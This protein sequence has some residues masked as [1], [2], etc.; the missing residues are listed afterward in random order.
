[1]SFRLTLL[2]FTTIFV[3]AFTSAYSSAQNP[4]LQTAMRDKLANAQ[5]LLGAVVTADY[6]AMDRAVNGL[7]RITEAEVL[8]WQVGGPPEYRKQAMSFIRSV[9]GLHEA[10]VKRDIDAALTEYSALIS[11]CTR[12]HAEV[13][14]LRVV[15]FKLP[16]PR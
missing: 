4:T 14:R 11:S 12:C 2:T 15:S 9:Q 10:V 5:R 8:S 1:M 16:A 13:R 7:S 3:L 6:A